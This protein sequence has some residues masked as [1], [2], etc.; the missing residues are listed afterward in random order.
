MLNNLKIHE[1]L[2]LGFGTLIVLMV[3][4]AAFTLTEIATIKYEFEDLLNDRYPKVVLSNKVIRQT[5]DNR[6][7]FRSALYSDDI[8]EI[9][10]LIALAEN[11]R[12]ANSDAFKRI[13]STLHT[14]KGK[15]MF[16]NI[17][18]ARKNVGTK[19]DQL[20]PLL[21]AKNP[22]ETLP[23][24]NREFTP[25]SDAFLTAIEKFNEAVADYMEQGRLNAA[26]SID[27]IRTTMIVSIVFCLL[28]GLIIAVLM[29]R[30]LSRQINEVMR[31]SE[32][33][34]QGDLTANPA[35][36][37][38]PGPRTEIGRLLANQEEMR[39]GLVRAL[40]EIRRST[41]QVDTSAGDLAS[42]SQEVANRVQ[43]QADSTTSASATLEELSVSID[44][45]A[46]ST[47][48]ASLQATR[49]GELAQQSAATVA[50]S[51]GR[52]QAVN[53]SVQQTAN[54]MADLKSEVA[55][56]GNI[57]TVIR[58]VADQT[59]LLALNAAIEAARA[60]E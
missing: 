16:A 22:A 59:N 42:A 31:R 11:N 35:A 3:A 32:K 34:A 28:V 6:W 41:A 36:G 53:G 33:I 24:L 5:L 47:R 27:T 51:V 43:Q 9:E 7:I 20:Y 23:F 17:I 37:A 30:S 10:K 26:R 48:D 18:E 21:R 1:K 19:Y 56:I 49:A 50:D 4:L 54:E 57:V 25:A 29:A 39:S 45:V 55:R 40:D 44:Q 60:G 52:I 58:E 38:Q 13:E 46:D 2:W 12:K 15:Q 8:N 14:E